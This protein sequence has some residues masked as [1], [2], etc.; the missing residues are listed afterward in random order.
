[1]QN[2]IHMKNN[3]YSWMEKISDK[4]ASDWTKIPMKPLDPALVEMQMLNDPTHSYET[5]YDLQPSY[6]NMPQYRGGKGGPSQ[7][8]RKYI[9][10]A[11]GSDF[12]K[13]NRRWGGDA[14]GT[15]YNMLG[16]LIGSDT[17]NKF[18]QNQR[19]AL[20]SYYYN[21]KP[22]S[23]T[24]T[25]KA[26]RKAM[27][28]GMTYDDLQSINKTIITGMNDKN[29]PG[30]KTRRLYEQQLFMKDIQPTGIVDGNLSMHIPQ[31]VLPEL[32][33]Q[34]ISVPIQQ[35]YLNNPVKPKIKIPFEPQPFLDSDGN[36][37]IFNRGKSGIHINPANRGKFNATKKRTGKTTEELTHSKNPL[38]RKRAI[39][40]LN[41]SKWNH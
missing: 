5:L 14:V 20:T 37:I 36:P 6:I 3:F 24:P 25:L 11:E 41:A 10:E 32:T 19:D 38:T 4:K 28:N 17:W 40:A 29:N 22:S 12:T 33:N 8:I 18:N 31:I 35:D 26:I 2:I 30:L 23:F 39:F 16:K 1:M 9:A 34:Q 13:Q 27:A 21:I 7:S 15:Y